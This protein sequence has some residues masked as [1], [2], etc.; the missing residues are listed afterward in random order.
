MKRFLRDYDRLNGEGDRTEE[1]QPKYIPYQYDFNKKTI[2]TRQNKAS[3]SIFGTQS[4]QKA[5]QRER[6]R[7]T[8]KTKREN[9]K[10]RENN[11]RE[12]KDEEEEE[13]YEHNID[14]A[15]AKFFEKRNKYGNFYKKDKQEDKDQQ[16][17]K[18]ETKKKPPKKK[19][20][21]PAEIDQN[22]RKYIKLFML[23]I[24]PDYFHFQKD[25]QE[26]SIYIERESIEGINLMG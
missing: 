10:Q 21:T 25:K 17:K 23:K 26:A 7:S 22:A 14:G 6:E 4:K 24:H 2:D 1:P 8:D 13:Y 16:Q 18:E 11:T 19:P 12:E 3:Q 15:F 9:D 5:E 20:P